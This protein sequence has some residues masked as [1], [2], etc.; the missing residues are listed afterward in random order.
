MGNQPHFC[1]SKCGK[2]DRAP[3][4]KAQ[5]KSP[6]TQ[7]FQGFFGGRGRRARTLGTRFWSGC[8]DSK[9][10]PNPA[11]LRYLPP[12]RI[13]FDAVL[14]LLSFHCEKVKICTRV[15]KEREKRFLYI[16]SY[17]RSGNNCFICLS[18]SS[19]QLPN[20][21][22]QI[23]SFFPMMNEFHIHHRNQNVYLLY[24]FC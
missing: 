11:P 24:H 7:R 5:R 21:H 1:A 13:V 4:S 8:R 16:G 17:V 10:H 14:M 20:T 12:A 22:F 9:N 23:H 15:N 3:F 2:A 6:E 19:K 18:K